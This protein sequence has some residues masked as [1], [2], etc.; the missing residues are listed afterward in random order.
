MMQMGMT[1]NFTVVDEVTTADI[2]KQSTKPFT[3]EELRSLGGTGHQA[4]LDLLNGALTLSHIGDLWRVMVQDALPRLLM[5]STMMSP[6]TV[7]TS[8]GLT[9][10]LPRSSAG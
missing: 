1:P 7:T 8:R 2:V 5:T 4:E 3:A 6:D 9:Y 10:R